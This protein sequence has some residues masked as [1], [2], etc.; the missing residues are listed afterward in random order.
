MHRARPG[1][2]RRPSPARRAD[3][4]E[5]SLEPQYLL[6]RLPGE[7]NES[8]PPPA[9]R[10]RVAG[11]TA[12]AA[13]GVHGGQE[14]PGRLRQA[15]VLRD[16]VGRLPIGPSVVQAMKSDTGCRASRP[17]CASAVGVRAR[18]TCSC[19][20]RE[21]A[22]LRAVAVRARR[23]RAPSRAAAGDRRVPDRRRG[24]A[25][26]RGRRDA[27]G[28]PAASCSRRALAR[29]ARVRTDERPAPRTA[30]RT[31]ERRRRGDRRR[32]T[33]ASRRSSLIERIIRQPTTPTAR[34]RPRAPRATAR[35]SAAVGKAPRTCRATAQAS[36]DGTRVRSGSG[37][38]PRRPRRPRARP[39]PT[40]AGQAQPGRA[41]P[42]GWRPAGAWA[43]VDRPRRGV[44]QSGSSSGS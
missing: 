28:R 25:D 4:A 13:H 21:L 38:V 8:F 12:R 42:T 19:P 5:R 44:E 14:R 31:T 1:S 17:C 32:P 35:G 34:R 2:D 11:E 18:P 20:D 37:V 3:H 43:T 10:A 41:P 29:D 40:T 23:R 24:D 33:D 26:G 7:E 9:V 15:R 36:G 30:D 6:M 39:R 16:A 27:A 22:A